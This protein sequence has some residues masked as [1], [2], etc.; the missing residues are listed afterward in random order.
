[1]VLIYLTAQNKD[2]LAEAYTMY[3]KAI[4]QRLNLEVD[5]KGR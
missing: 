2:Y 3:H 1:M 4:L 5:S